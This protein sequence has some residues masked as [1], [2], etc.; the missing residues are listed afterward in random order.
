MK[1]NIWRTLQLGFVGM[2]TLIVSGCGDI[3]VSDQIKQDG[4]IFCGQGT[5]SSF[6]PQLVDNDIAA[7]ALGPQIFNTLVHLSNKDLEL[8]PMLASSWTV[9]ESGTVY[10]FKL[11]PDVSFQTTDWFTP[12]RKLSAQDVVFT[13]E[14]II[15]SSHPFHYVSGGT[16][17]WF[18][19]I[20]FKRILKEVKAVDEH[21][22][23]FELFKPDNTFLT[24]LSTTYSS[25]HSSEYANQ[26]LAKDQ[27]Q[28]LDQLPVGTG[29][30]Y[31]D[32][33]SVND[34]IRLR[35]NPDFWGTPA[36][37]EQVVLDI[38]SRG[39]GTLAKLLRSECDVLFSPRSSQIPTIQAHPDLVLQAYPSMNVAF[40]ALRTLN[41]ALNDARVRKALNLAINRDAIID[42]VYYGYGTSA[43][44]IL[45]PESWAYQK[46]SS[47][48]RYDRNYARALIREAGYGT[49][50]ELSLW[51][52]LEP[53]AYN[54]S[55]RKVAELLQ[56][57]FADIGVKLNIFLDE[58][59]SRSTFQSVAEADMIL[60]GWNADTSDPDNFFRPLLSCGAD[61]AGLNIASWCNPDFDALIDIAKETTQ[62]R[63]RF[64]LYRQ[65]QNL[66]NEEVPIIPIA[67][68]M[69]FQAKHKSLKGFDASPF[70]TLSFE[71]VERSK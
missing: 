36:K 15:D 65:A 20:G 71:N 58:R 31:L 46:N 63:H 4:F 42:S 8:K 23:Q 29:P 28:N 26:L 53:T 22:V 39:T 3:E 62:K 2:C 60:T 70:N 66:L 64:N 19:A 7:E 40:I 45:P 10:Q 44:S 56:S 38:T 1:A 32:Q 25:I 14:R 57:N 6:N 50:L 49:G 51:V 18:E 33:F 59:L 24:N 43:Y 52:A 21:T 68:G 69:Q 12:T 11:R 34:Y 17:P 54:P 27:K 9:D 5:P 61:R 30:F 55:P 41:P 13:F 47:Q 35:R 48:V 16:Y 67:H 37:M